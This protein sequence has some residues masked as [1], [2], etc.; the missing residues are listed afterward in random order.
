MH[1]EMF[2]KFHVIESTQRLHFTVRER[3]T[4][5][6]LQA[7]INREYKFKI[8][9]KKKGGGGGEKSL[10]WDSNSCRSLMLPYRH[11]NKKKV[12]LYFH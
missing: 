10:F 7:T 11:D 12:W 8:K 2:Y 5:A 9:I 6:R 1:V 3:I 4:G